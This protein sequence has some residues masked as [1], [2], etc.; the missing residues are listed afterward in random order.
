MRWRAIRV[1]WAVLGIALAGPVPAQR[2]GPPRKGTSRQMPKGK[3]SMIP[4][5]AEAQSLLLRST[6][7]VLVRIESAE[8]GPWAQDSS[9]ATRRTAELRLIVEDVMKGDVA[10]GQGKTV[11][12]K[13]T[14]T[15]RT[16]TRYYAL[17][18]VWSAHDVGAGTRLVAFSISAS[19]AG[20]DVLSERRLQM[21]LPPEEA[22]EDVRLFRDV[23]GGKLPL[24]EVLG[25][26]NRKAGGLHF[27]FADYV[28]DRVEASPNLGV[29]EMEALGTHLELPSL[30]AE[31]RSTLLGSVHSILVA[32]D[33]A[34]APVLER[35]VT[36]LFHLIALP[37]AGD[38][39]NIIQV[40]LPNIAG[41]SGGAKRKSAG[42]VFAAHPEERRRAE[43]ILRKYVGPAPTGKLLEW[44]R[45]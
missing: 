23:E 4:V 33:P 6:H 20:V 15:R 22:L 11:I 10:E 29:L 40:Y 38:V 8:V 14:Q 2:V 31:A 43:E 16:G 30:T 36:T 41:I 25:M 13:A 27:L 24:H 34:P 17:P 39:D 12:V 42:A 7:I 3:D 26:A 5:N 35:W 37:A 9:G 45:E 28:G 44:L 21:L 18:G 19:N 32:S 1:A